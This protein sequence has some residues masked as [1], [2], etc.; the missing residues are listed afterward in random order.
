[1]A[2]PSVMSVPALS[3]YG[4]VV[5]RGGLARN[6]DEAATLAARLGFP[7]ALKI[8]S[9]DILHKTDIGGV[10]LGLDSE[11]ALRAAYRRIEAAAHAQ[12]PEARVEGV[13]V[14]EMVAGGFEIIIGLKRDDQFGSVIMFGLGGIFTELLDDVSFRVLPIAPEDARQM[15]AETRGARMLQGYRGQA[16]VA[17]ASLVDLL[18][19]AARLGLDL[20]DRLESVD[21]NPIAVW[22]EEHRVL[23]YKVVTRER[24]AAGDQA[25]VASGS[26]FGELGARDADTSHLATFFEARSVALVGASATPGKIGYAVLDSLAKHQY[27]GRGLPREPDQGFPHGPED[28]PHPRAPYLDRS[29]WSCAPSIWQRCRNSYGSVPPAASTTWSWYP[30][31]AR[32]WEEKEPLWRQ[33]SATCPATWECG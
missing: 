4:F 7:V 29:N 11:E 24:P 2:P 10:E 33:R 30:G 15:V 6:A 16:P 22:G 13:Q 8:V 3:D 5:P 27:R 1:M 19:A 9:P 18:L 20:G 17:P 31:V 25:S 26:P 32:S 12:A 21:L 14:E 28:L 23:D